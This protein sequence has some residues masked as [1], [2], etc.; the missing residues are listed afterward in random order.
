MRRDHLSDAAGARGAR[1]DLSRVP[2]CAGGSG[3]DPESAP[4]GLDAEEWQ[5]LRMVIDL[6]KQNAS[7]AELGPVLE[8]I[9]QAL[10]S[11]AAKLIES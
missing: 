11:D 8:T 1:E 6:I 7:G 10:R 2:E 9:E 3:H 5:L 4:G